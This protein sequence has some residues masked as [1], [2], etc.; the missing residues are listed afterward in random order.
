MPAAMILFT[1]FLGVCLTVIPVVETKVL[2]KGHETGLEYVHATVLW[3]CILTLYLVILQ[4]AKV[5][6]SYTTTS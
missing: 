5:R 2:F 1:F 6:V 3:L 4:L